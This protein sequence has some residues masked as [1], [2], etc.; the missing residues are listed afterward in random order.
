MAFWTE[1]FL[2]KIREE[3]ARRIAQ[4]QYC[5]AGVWHD[6]TITEKKVIGNV[7]RITSAITEDAAREITAWRLV[8]TGGVVAG[9][10]SE[11]LTKAASQ[12]VVTEWEFPLYEIT[13]RR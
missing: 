1:T 12:G 7:I 4:I 9:Q 8:D 2:V 13:E 6:A 11:S 10:L 5:A 3:F